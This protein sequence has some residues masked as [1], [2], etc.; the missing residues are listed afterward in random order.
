MIFE[1]R[2][3]AALLLL[4]ALAL[5]A[6]GGGSTTA[7]VSV[8]PG[9]K[10][11][12]V[13]VAVTGGFGEKPSLTVPSGTA[14]TKLSSEALAE[15]TGPAVMKGQ[16]AVV[17]YLGQTWDL[18][19]GKP[20][21]FD[22]SYDHQQPFSFLTGAG[23]VISGWD[24]SIVGA[25]IGSRLLL[26]VPPADGYN[27]SQG[28]TNELTGKTLLFV[29]DVLDAIGLDTSATGT[30]VTTPLPAGLPT[31]ASQP[32]K[33]PAVTSVKGV[34][35]PKTPLSAL[36][37][38]GSGPA[39]DPAKSLALQVVQTDVA[40]GKQTEQTWGKL[41]P[42]IWPAKNVTALVPALKGAPVGSRAVAV[43]PADA[44]AQTPALVVVVDVI[45]QY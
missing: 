2:R 18:K 12:K 17:N 26:T 34:T 31:V 40:T 45:R 39:I 8:P 7:K 27:A 3:L 33:A 43:L 19:D 11:T 4:P 32:G 28:Q 42:S 24:K 38:K 22:N 1:P 9:A 44:Q 36:L 13:G 20:N 23:Q 14:P 10:L 15:G 29:V 37:I 25:K 16:S 21:V 35:P 30:P 41:G 5:A 6:C